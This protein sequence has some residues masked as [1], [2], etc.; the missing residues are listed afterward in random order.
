MNMN[1]ALTDVL[2]PLARHYRA[3]NVVELRMSR[4]GTVVLDRRGEGKLTKRDGAL[5]LAAVESV[6]QALANADSINFNSADNP[7]L[8]CVIP[9]MR[10]RFECA[11]GP[12]IQ[13]GLSLAVRC[14]HD[15]APDWAQIGVDDE[16]RAYFGECITRSQNMIISGATNTGKT[17]FL[18]MLIAM[19]PESRRVVA[20]EDTPEVSI[21]RFY[22]GVGLIAGRNN[23]ANKGMLSWRQLYDHVMRISPDNIVFGEISTQN[24]YPALGALNSGSRGFLCTIHAHSPWQALNRKFD[25]NIAWSGRTMP[26]VPEFLA[27]LIDVVV[28]LT[29]DDDGLRRVSHVYEPRAN[30]YVLGTPPELHQL[31][32]REAA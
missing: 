14:K 13:T 6:C 7:Q 24:A 16:L 9:G 25:H 18:N 27:D 29:R 19:L 21:D 2:E 5:T 4:P 12:S 10:H 1:R 30:R 31:A 28:Q 26:K 15:F 3:T 17:T 32:G 23:D 8:S 20:I 22:D 11:V